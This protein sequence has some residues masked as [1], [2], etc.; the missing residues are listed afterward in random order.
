M[1]KITTNLTFINKEWVDVNMPKDADENEVFLISGKNVHTINCGA[2]YNYSG[3]IKVDFPVLEVIEERAFE[4][5]AIEEIKT[6]VRFVGKEAFS[7]SDIKKVVFTNN[8]LSLGDYAFSDCTKLEEVKFPQGISKVN[9]AAFWESK[10]FDDLPSPTFINDTLIK[11][12]EKEVE[13]PKDVKYI[14]P[15][16]TEYSNAVIKTDHPVSF[17][18]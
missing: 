17:M 3:K 10:W 5:A 8:K 16:L 12:V 4:G 2:F 11:A 15:G 18:K 7:Y 13:I 9:G 6:N 14:A 1:K